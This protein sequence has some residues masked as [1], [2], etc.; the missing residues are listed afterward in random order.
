MQKNTT[1]NLRVTFASRMSAKIS[2]SLSD[3]RTFSSSGWSA[4]SS[5]PLLSRVLCV[6]LSGRPTCASGCTSFTSLMRSWQRNKHML[7]HY[8]HKHIWKHYLQ[9]QM[10]KHYFRKNTSKH[11]LHTNIS[12]CCLWK[13]K[14]NHQSLFLDT[15]IQ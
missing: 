10:L 2:I 15:K 4:I 9:K 6:R 14:K 1:E 5:S 7:K 3:V 11:Y 8:L 12:K 13:L